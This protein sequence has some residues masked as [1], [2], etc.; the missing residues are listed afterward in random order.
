MEVYFK[1]SGPQYYIE[2][3]SFTP[4]PLYPPNWIEGCARPIA[5][6]DAMEKRKIVPLLGLKPQPVAKPTELSQL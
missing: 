6:L 3:A 4:L 5:S 2:V 1:Y